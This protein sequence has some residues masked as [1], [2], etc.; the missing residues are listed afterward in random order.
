MIFF[1]PQLLQLRPD[2]LDKEG[3]KEEEENL[4]ATYILLVTILT[5]LTIF[6]LINMIVLLLM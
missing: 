2:S 3:Q 4:G 6:L 1:S 5:L